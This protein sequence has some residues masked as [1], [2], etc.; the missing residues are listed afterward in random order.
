M[1]SVSVGS[2]SHETSHA[3]LVREVTHLR[4]LL[5]KSQDRFEAIFD[6]VTEL[7]TPEQK[8]VEFV[9]I[10]G[11]QAEAERGLEAIAAEFELDAPSGPIRNCQKCGATIVPADGVKLCSDCWHEGYPEPAENLAPKCCQDDG[12]NCGEHGP[13]RPA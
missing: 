10:Q 9:S 6:R 11:I 8:A 13:G 5:K 2:R 1:A 7:W 4:A 3:V 12:A